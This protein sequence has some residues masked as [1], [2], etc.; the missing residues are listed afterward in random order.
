MSIKKLLLGRPKCEC[1]EAHICPIKQVIIKK[2]ALCELKATA[3]GY[4]SILLVADENTYKA[5][6]ERAERELGGKI[7][8]RV[9]FDGSRILVPDEAAIAKIQSKI[10]ENTDLILGVGSGVINDLCKYTSFAAGLPYHIIATAPSMD[11][12]A[13]VGAALILDGMK[14]TVD[15]AVPEAIIADTSVLANAPIDMIVA[16]YGDIIGKYSCLNDWKLAALVRDEYICDYVVN[17]TYKEVKKVRARIKGLL[18]GDGDA[19]GAL[20]EALVSVG[21][22]MAY[23]GNSRP[24][25]GS[26]H[27]LSHYFEI[28]GIERGEKYLP[29]GTD[30]FYSSALTAKLREA[31][32][33]LPDIPNLKSHDS[34]K[35]T[36]NIKRVYCSVAPEVLALQE[37]LGFYR[38][39]DARLEVYREKWQEIKQLLSEAPSFAEVDFMLREAGLTY[40]SFVKYYGERKLTD[41]TLFAKDLKDRYTVLWLYYDIFGYCK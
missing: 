29:H 30:V 41:A 2:D 18:S 39:K 27:H 31:L 7:C 12:Y 34:E 1:N 11:G 15:S 23:V 25:S 8:E 28:V 33:E 35:Y 10:N 36:E 20:M 3:S 26:E 40:D 19:V 16:G 14:V 24:A 9:I 4:K 37:R 13:S 38:E 17:S 6:G 21:I 22:L 5:A 32:T